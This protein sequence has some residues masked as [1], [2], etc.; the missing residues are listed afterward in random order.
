MAHI[1]AKG[2]TRSTIILKGGIQVD[3]IAMN[4]IAGLMAVPP[5]AAAQ[6]S[7]DDCGASCHG[8]LGRKQVT[9]RRPLTRLSK[10]TLDGRNLMPA[11][12]GEVS[13]ISAYETPAGESR[14]LQRL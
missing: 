3:M 6:L 14:T 4:G 13:R 10:F 9:P 11:L 1:L 7:R 8:V 5:S 2:D 12:E